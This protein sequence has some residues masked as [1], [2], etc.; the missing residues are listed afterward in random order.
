MYKRIVIVVAVLALAFSAVGVATALQDPASVVK[1]MVSTAKAAVKSASADD[2]KAAIDKKE[3]AIILD[4]R[5]PGE[6]AAGHLPGAINVPRGLLEFKVAKAIPD[7]NAK[8]YV[9]CASGGRAA[10]ATKVL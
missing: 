6:F 7:L 8:I 10:L 1:G 3:K 9:Y 5:E 4:V 2:L